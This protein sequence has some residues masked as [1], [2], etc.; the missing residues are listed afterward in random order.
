MI[1]RREE[2]NME[3]IREYYLAL[4]EEEPDVEAWRWCEENIILTELETDY[5]GHLDT[6]LTPWIRLLLEWVRDDEVEEIT[7][8]AGTQVIKTLFLLCAVTWWARHRGTRMLFVMDTK[9]NAS[10]FSESR[11]QPLFEN[12]PSLNRLKPSDPHKWNKLKMYIGRGLIN[13]VGSNSPGN[14]A[15]RPAPFIAMDEVGKFKEKTEKET[16]A[17]SLA[18]SRTKSKLRRKVI[19]T[20]SPTYEFGLEWKSFLRGSQHIW[21]IKCPH[22]GKYIE[23]QKDNIRWCP[24]AKRGSQWDMQLVRDT[25]HYCCQECGGFIKSSDKRKLNRTADWF[26]QNHRAP[27]NIRSARIPS[28]Y[29]PWESCSFGSVAVKFLQC[30]REFNMKDFDNNWDARP[31]LDEVEKLD[32]EILKERKESYAQEYPDRVAYCTGFMDVQKDW[33]EW[34]CIGWGENSEHWV[35]EHEVIHLDPSVEDS[36]DDT[37]D[38]VLKDRPVP[39][40]WGFYDFGGHWHQ[41]AINFMQR[42]RKKGIRNLHLSFG[43]TDDKLPERGRRTWTKKNLKPKT[44]LFE[45]GV[46][47]AKSKIYKM[48]ARGG[49]GRGRCHF[50]D[51]LDDE[52]FEQ[53]CAEE[54]RPRTEKGRTV[55]HWVNGR[56]NGRNEAIDGHVGCYVGM[57][58]IPPATRQKHIVEMLDRIKKAKTDLSPGVNDEPPAANDID[59][60]E[61]AEKRGRRSSGSRGRRGG[62][63]VGNI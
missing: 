40:L 38:T 49:T 58:Q 23:L 19:K 55:Y 17:V 63:F 24:L 61:K 51:W 57:L 54:R 9:D 41:N 28:Y 8:I 20:S 50:P 47:Q 21:K 4:W 12:S 18:E 31:S 26:Q 44:R 30:K 15:S 39:L 45:M 35:L 7:I 3:E 32:W 10:D 33:F 53:L 22:C 62:G 37:L 42:L 13:L 5:P 14:L 59:E 6:D 25:A 2:R 27:R 1:N 34:F 11:L 56:S 29:S 60:S 46:G 36:W 48:L 16:D 52:Y 43:S